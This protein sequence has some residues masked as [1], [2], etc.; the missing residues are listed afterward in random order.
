MAAAAAP[1]L[2][3][4]G[5]TIIG[6]MIASNASKGGS[7]QASSAM[8]K[9]AYQAA[10]DLGLP[11]DTAKALVY[12]EY[13]K[14]GNYT[15]ELEQEINAGIS[16]AEQIKE[17]PQL[18]QQQ[19]AALNI[20]AQRG[21]GGMTPEDR[22]AMNQM[23]DDVARDT[24]A[25]R[26][27]IIQSYQQRG[28]GGSGAEIAA[29]LVAA[30]GGSNQASAGGDRLATLSSQNALQAM[31]QGGQ[32]AGQMRQQDFSVNNAKATAADEMKRFDVQNQ[33]ARQQRNVA[34]QNQANQYNMSENQKYADLNT[35]Q[36]NQEQLRQRD[37]QERYWQNMKDRQALVSNAANG[38]ASNL[39]AKAGQEAQSAA[40]LS[41][42]I[43]QGATGVA[44]ALV[45]NNSTSTPN[46]NTTQNGN[47]DSGYLGV[48]TKLG[49]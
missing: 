20:L 12:Q 40:N 37:A 18:M 5:G 25:K 38:A 10:L 28:M 33:I 15:P 1:A 11:P 49:Y 31:T 3:A 13:K 14:Q 27:Q 45:K 4:A 19:Q 44:S 35:Q 32:L 34:S 39:T 41:S 36:A 48:D 43:I 30:Q 17:N 9:Q 23:R 29:Q 21:K 24:E 6:S 46:T 47:I 42:G 22:A 26:Q 2:I 8:V 16:Q 7:A